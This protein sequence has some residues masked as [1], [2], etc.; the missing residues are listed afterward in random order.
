MGLM[1][2]TVQRLKMMIMHAEQTTIM[3]MMLRIIM[4]INPYKF[5]LTSLNLNFKGMFGLTLECLSINISV[6]N[7]VVLILVAYGRI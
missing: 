6:V 5:C 1:I 4:V 2:L 3:T 7:F